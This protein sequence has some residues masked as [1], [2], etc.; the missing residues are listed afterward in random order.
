M[1]GLDTNVVVRYLV[2]DD[3]K[4]AALAV[5]AIETQC[6]PAQ[7]GFISQIVLCELVWV[8]EQCYRQN[9][10]QVALILEKLMKTNSLYFEDLPLLWRSL[11]DYS[12]NGVDFADALIAHKS[13]NHQ[14][15]TTL[16]F[17]KKAAK[18][19]AFSYLN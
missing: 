16:T 19:A 11:Q 1:I 13:I 15:S 17:D 14:C 4:Q 7:P 6:T 5:K 12:I 9:R 2:Q 10:M 8:L 18:L 3:P